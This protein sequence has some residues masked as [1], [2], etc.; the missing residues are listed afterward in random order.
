MYRKVI[1]FVVYLQEKIQLIL[2]F[3]DEKDAR[4]KVVIFSTDNFDIK[5]EADKII[6]IEFLEFERY[7]L[8]KRKRD[9]SLN[10]DLSFR[11]WPIRNF[12]SAI[13]KQ[14]SSLNFPLISP[15]ATKRL[16]EKKLLFHF[17]AP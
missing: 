3:R 6:S 16:H 1:S 4:P 14:I 15:K 11:L 7:F 13:E 9:E 2:V 12:H 5:I 10:L 8:I 17:A